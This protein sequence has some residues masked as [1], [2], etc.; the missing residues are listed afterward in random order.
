[1]KIGNTGLPVQAITEPGDAVFLRQSV[2]RRIL[3]FISLLVVV[4]YFCS[5]YPLG[6]NGVTM[7]IAGSEL[8]DSYMIFYTS[9]YGDTPEYQG[10]Y[11][12]QDDHEFGV[13]WGLPGKRADQ[14]Y[15]LRIGHRQQKTSVT[16]LVFVQTIAGFHFPL[17]RVTGSNMRR[18]IQAFQDNTRLRSG[19]ETLELYSARGWGPEV[20][21]QVPGSR[22]IHNLPALLVWK[23]H[24]VWAFLFILTVLFLYLCTGVRLGGLRDIARRILFSRIEFSQEKI[25][26]KMSVCLLVLTLVVFFAVVFARSWSNLTHPG[27]YVEDGTQY[28]SLYYGERQPFSKVLSHPHKYMAV[29]TF[30]TAWLAAKQDVRLQPTI[31]LMV[32]V[33]MCSMVSLLL[34][35]TGLLQ[36]PVSIVLSPVILGTS[37]IIHIYMW[38]T[39]SYQIFVA[40]ILLL[41]LLFYSPPAR[42]I[43][44]LVYLAVVTLLVW[45]APYSVLA[46]PVAMAMLILRIFPHR[47]KAM[48][49]GYVIICA[50]G[51]LS[52]LESGTVQLFKLFSNRDIFQHFY[53]T[54]FE[55]IF[56]MDLFGKVNGAKIL[57]LTGLLVAVFWYFRKDVFYLKIASTFMLIVFLN[58]FVYFSSTKYMLYEHWP[59]HLQISLFFWYVFLIFSID[60]CRFSADRSK[61]CFSL[62]WLLLLSVCLYDNIVHAE[63][64]VVP[65][66]NNLPE[67]LATVH[68][69]EGRRQELVD[70]QEY[71]IIQTDG[72]W[73]SFEK[74]TGPAIWIG[75]ISY[76]N[77]LK[78]IID[79]SSL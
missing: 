50:L 5:Q 38:N 4:F 35:C 78:K 3:F 77:H 34:G 68:E 17:L 26:G 46:I 15:L 36:H 2:P 32:A 18:Y 29:G 65:V 57:L 27:L 67:F 25:R 72:F 45:S 73:R 64:R 75:N 56:F 58:L 23:Y 47:C 48:L 62:A 69:W 71:V 76:G 41:L 70:Q 1:M 44:C 55:N 52:T 12:S 39:L 74:D 30:L 43:P 61:R 66:M 7:R 11:H 49:L 8:N 63:K 20:V 31:Y 10:V 79:I 16:E 9:V 19:P 40:A 21:L 13:T 42:C 14:E 60:R 33:L 6:V 51:Y 24:C 37:G 54:L 22:I 59:N 53:T 28:F